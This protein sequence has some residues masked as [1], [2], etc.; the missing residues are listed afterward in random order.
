MDAG[1]LVICGIILLIYTLIV[2]G[3]AVSNGY[4]Q[5]RADGHITG[6]REG[7]GVNKAREENKGKENGS[8]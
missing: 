1:G 4:N 7:L 3:I 6:M 2:Y 5:G 8:N